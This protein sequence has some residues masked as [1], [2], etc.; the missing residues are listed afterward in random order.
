MGGMTDSVCYA[1]ISCTLR[2]SD[3]FNQHCAR[4]ALTCK[5]APAGLY[6]AMFSDAP[7]RVIG[8]EGLSAS[9][10]FVKTRGRTIDGIDSGR[11]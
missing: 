2:K 6:I 4:V 9:P 1:R 3:S 8:V 5:M 7:S 11:G 10:I